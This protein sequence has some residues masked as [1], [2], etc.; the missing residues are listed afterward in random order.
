MVDIPMISGAV[1]ALKA[2]GD[3]V[4]LI[5]ASHDSGVIRQKVGELQTQIL[6]AQEQALGAYAD[7]LT[8]L[9]R[10]G[11]LEKQIAGFETWEAQ[12]KRYEMK[13]VATGYIVYA[14]KAQ[15]SGGE[16][17]HWICASC[18]QNDKKSIL[19]AG[20]RLMGSPT[21]AWIC[22]VCKTEL[23]IGFKDQRL[24]LPD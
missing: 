1:G 17:P 22:P 5:I 24:I 2:A 8:L 6:A 11:E 15:E 3:A 20:E 16:P 4:K 13:E 21:G 23:L 18:Y 9:K 14:L 12:K 19:Q 7:Y 10:I